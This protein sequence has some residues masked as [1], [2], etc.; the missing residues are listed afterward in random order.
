MG[1]HYL[2][3]STADARVY[4]VPKEN[5][6]LLGTLGILNAE[7][8]PVKLIT[9]D[10]QIIAAE[11]LP[12]IDLDE[13]AYLWEPDNADI[14]VPNYSATNLA[15]EGEAK[16]LFSSLNIPIKSNSQCYQRAHLWAHLMWTDTFTRS[17]KVFLFFTRRYIEDYKYKWWFHVSPFVYVNGD[18]RVL[19]YEFTNGPLAMRRWTDVFIKPKV[20]CPL[21]DHY[22]DYSE[23]QFEELCY[24]REVP[25]YYYQPINVKQSDKTGVPINEFQEWDLNHANKVRKR[26]YSPEE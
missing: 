5:S 24:I 12:K 21:I 4:Q 10:D 6:D 20:N 23:H 3:L 2:V 9:D 14:E 1:T 19:D 13:P 22:E 17:M 18:P 26:S 25:M 16:S 7:L 15:T 8:S 11:P